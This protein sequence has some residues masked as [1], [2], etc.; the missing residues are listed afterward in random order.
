MASLLVAEICP[1]IIPINSSINRKR[2][3]SIYLF[4][5]VPL[6]TN[7]PIMHTVFNK[8]RFFELTEVEILLNKTDP[9]INAYINNV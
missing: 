5:R 7:A 8:V 4:S 9:R 2:Q 1:D 6:N 3:N